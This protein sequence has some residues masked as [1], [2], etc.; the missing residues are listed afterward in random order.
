MDSANERRAAIGDRAT[1]T[2]EEV[3]QWQ[4]LSS[5]QFLTIVKKM[6]NYLVS[7][8]G[9]RTSCAPAG[10]ARSASADHFPKAVRDP[11]RDTLKKEHR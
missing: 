9:S 5:R 3:S 11:L 2:I 7:F 8:S 4:H 10:T 1:V 6:K